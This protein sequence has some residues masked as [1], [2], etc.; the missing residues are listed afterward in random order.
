MPAHLADTPDAARELL[1]Y[2]R[3]VFD[4]FVRR[5]ARLSW[6][7]AS[8]DRGIGHHSL[9]GTLVHVLNVHEAW[10]VYVVPGRTRELSARFAEADRRPSDWKGFRAYERRVWS[11]V[12]ATVSRLTRRDLARRVKAPWMPGEYTAA[13][14]LLQTT[15]EQAHHIGEIIGA[16]WQD[17]ES[18]SRMT[19]IEVMRRSART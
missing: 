12:S 4:R 16:L 8:R 1:R 13:D 10:M 9:F 11:G 3:S 15:I 2:N 6:K 14:A 17:D 7:E 19:W 18:T 5:V